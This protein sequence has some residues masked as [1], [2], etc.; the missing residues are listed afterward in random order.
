MLIISTPQ[1]KKIPYHDKVISSVKNKIIEIDP[2]LL[3]F[4]WILSGSFAVNSL[5]SP[6]QDFNDIDFY[7]TSQ[8]DFTDCYHYL[9]SKVNQTSY[10]TDNAITFNNLNLQL[11]NKWF[12]P[13]EE[14]IYSHDFT[15]VSVAITKDNIYTTK[16]TNYS[17]YNEQL[18][19]RNFQI[20][21]NP[22]ATDFEIVTALNIL[23]TRV[24]KYLT[25]YEFSLS[26][27]FKKFY[28]DQLSFLKNIDSSQFGQNQPPV[29]NYY[30]NLINP[31][32]AIQTAIYDINELLNINPSNEWDSWSLQ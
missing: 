17:W 28:Y 14:L 25:R 23:N 1:N 21:K 22:P 27:S 31:S 4:N 7:F 19:L 29:Y 5:Y 26:P 32:N 2:N 6:N 30:G 16:E 8:Q 12:L 18:N 13:P 24:N 9:L 20:S 11:I 3:Q 10:C 15:N